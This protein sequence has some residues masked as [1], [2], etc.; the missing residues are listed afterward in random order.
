MKKGFFVTV[1]SALFFVGS[2][3]VFVAIQSSLAVSNI[4]GQVVQMV[5]ATRRHLSKSHDYYALTSNFI[6]NSGLAP[7]GMKLNENNAFDISGNAE[8][9]IVSLIPY[10]DFD[11]NFDQV[12]YLTCKGLLGDRSVLLGDEIQPE[13]LTVNGF[14]LPPRPG[15]ESACTPF[16]PNSFTISYQ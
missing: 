5:N 8:M 15:V 11:L 12:S 16:G 4:N 13:K 10:R 9:S 6:S 3:Y 2:A 1:L 14:K 7:D